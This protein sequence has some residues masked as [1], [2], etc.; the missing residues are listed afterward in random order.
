M[1][2]HPVAVTVA[3]CTPAWPQLPRAACAAS[4]RCARTTPPTRITSTSSSSITTH[5]HA[6]ARR[7][8]AAARRPLRPRGSPA[9]LDFAQPRAGLWGLRPAADDPAG[10]LA[11][12]WHF[13]GAHV[14]ARGQDA[15]F[16]WALPQPDLQHCASLAIATT[17]PARCRQRLRL[18]S[19]VDAA[20]AVLPLTREPVRVPG[21]AHERRRAALGGNRG[22]LSAGQ[23]K[24][25]S[26][27]AS[28]RLRPADCS[29]GEWTRFNGTFA[30]EADCLADVQ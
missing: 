2:F 16:I 11:R 15:E 25:P 23:S 8:R 1:A 22:L 30:T 6:A 7:R 10:P 13:C 20:R 17:P 18:A 3:I 26:D 21:Y 14:G 24:A 4:S 12:G 28:R 9:G 5:D 29:S 19:A 27:C